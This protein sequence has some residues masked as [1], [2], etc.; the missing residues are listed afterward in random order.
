MTDVKRLL[1]DIT[2]LKAFEITRGKS[3]AKLPYIVLNE[4][5][6]NRGADDKNLLKERSIT[7]ELYTC[8]KEH[9]IEDSIE[10]K[11]NE[12]GI[13]IKKGESTWIDKDYYMMTPFYFNLIERM[14]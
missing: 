4:S 14:M 5:T 13:E 11:F 3:N 1:E 2:G 12:K 10:R 9:E 6:N 7:I 8:K